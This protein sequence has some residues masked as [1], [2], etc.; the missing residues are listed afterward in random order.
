MERLSLSQARR[1]TLRAQGL[2]APRPVRGAPP[3]MRHFQQVV[4]RL[5]VLQIDSV[6]VLARAHLMPTYSRIGA[7]DASLLD[8]A[9]G[10]APRRLV[11]TW[12][13]MASFVPPETFRLLGWRQRS[14]LTEAWG[15][16]ADVPLQHT[17]LLR[18]IREIITARGP[19][20]ARQV[21]EGFEAEHPTTRTE[22]GW[23]WT[24]AKRVLEFLFF[25]GEVTSA[26][27]NGAF[28]RRYDLTSRVLPPAVLAAPEPSESESVRALME[29]GARAHGI[30]T[31]RSFADYFRIKL[32]PAALAVAELVEEGVLAEVTVDGWDEG[33]VWW[34]RDA[35]LPRRATG[36]ALLNPFDPLVFERRRVEALFGLRYR[37]EIYVPEPKRVWGYYVLPFLLGESLPALVDLKADRQAGVLRVQGAHRSPGAQVEVVEEL[38]AELRDLALWLGLDDVAV[39]DRGDLAASLKATMR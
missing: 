8:T 24:V 1:L 10:K 34:H 15:S 30:G 37:I 25:T 23:N 33:P 17:P 12:A 16:I 27:R 7:Y 3:T 21:Q 26:G 35:T 39:T 14:Y 32:A 2:D 13:H 28:E 36:R 19:M 20:T 11:E 18:E 29:I 31:L 22:W 6:N 5:G 4:D 9:S 38:A